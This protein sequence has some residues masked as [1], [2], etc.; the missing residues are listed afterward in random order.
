M[1]KRDSIRAL[2]HIARI[3]AAQYTTS[4]HY[5]RDQQAY[6]WYRNLIEMRATRFARTLSQLDHRTRVTESFW[7]I[8]ACRLESHESKRIMQLSI[9]CAHRGKRWQASGS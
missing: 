9:S 1:Y 2:T 8:C 3:P 7:T 4:L 5:R 6:L